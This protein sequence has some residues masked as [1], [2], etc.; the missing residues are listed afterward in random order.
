M[1][2]LRPYCAGFLIFSDYM[3]EP[4]RLASLEEVP[5]IYVFTHDSIGVGEDGPTHQPIEQLA[6]LR[7][8]PNLTVIRPGDANE[9]AE[10]YRHALTETS[11][12]TVLALSRQPLPTL[13]R[14]KYA[15]ASGLAK[16]AY[17]LADAAPG[18]VPELLLI[19]TG[20]ETAICVEAFETLKSEGVK[21]R[22]VSLPSW[23][24]FDVQSDEYKESVLPKAVKKRV[25]VEMASTFGWE[26]YAG[27]T[28]A[29]IGMRSWASSAPLKDLLKA[30]GFTTEAVLKAAREQLA[31]GR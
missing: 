8:V 2:K 13:D 27:D 3:R 6:N 15:S 19:T 23:G 30:F 11:L 24:L 1:T 10:A 21:V 7:A 14:S 31:G 22:L 17:V 26:R 28:G 12:P 16:G 4:I 25:C 20:S 18:E 9:V 29:I 5:I